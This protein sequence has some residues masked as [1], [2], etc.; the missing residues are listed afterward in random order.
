MHIFPRLARPIFAAAF[1]FGLLFGI[2]ISD[3]PGRLWRTSV[4]AFSGRFEA[5]SQL[6]DDAMAI[7]AFPVICALI[8]V[9]TLWFL[10]SLV[11][12]ESKRNLT[13]EL[14]LGALSLVPAWVLTEILLGL[15][16]GYTSQ[17]S[18]IL[19]VTALALGAISVVISNNFEK[20]TITMR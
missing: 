4:L 3:L 16:G 19:L 17:H 12:R 13:I 10:A 18:S 7:L 1:A 6:A 8:S 5:P 20:R 11:N 15:A 9:L 2:T 14:I